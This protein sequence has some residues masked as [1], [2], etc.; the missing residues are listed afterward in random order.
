MKHFSTTSDTSCPVGKVKLKSLPTQWRYTGGVHVQ[1]HSFL[2]SALDGDVWST[3]HASRP[4]P[5]NASYLFNRRVNGPQTESGRNG[6]D[7]YVCPAT[8]FEP[9]IVQPV[10]QSL[11]TTVFRLFLCLL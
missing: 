4:I 11:L 3:S 9:Q 1:L 5:N 2:T 10:A 7:I 6:E 8:G